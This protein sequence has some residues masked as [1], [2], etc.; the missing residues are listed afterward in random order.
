MTVLTVPAI[1]NTEPPT[2]LQ[3][4]ESKDRTV[5]KD[6]VDAYGNFVWA[7]AKKF[8]HSNEEAEAAAQEIFIDIWRYAELGDQP[9][10]HE[11]LL[12]GLI[13]RRRLVKYLE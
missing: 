3:R 8:T 12:I 1:I 6:G 9:R 2:I 10:T 5:V 4:I 7:L 11:N 13:A